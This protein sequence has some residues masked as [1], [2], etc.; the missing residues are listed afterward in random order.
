M[1]CPYNSYAS[2]LT[3]KY[4]YRIFRVGVDAGF[5]C[6]NRCKNKDGLGCVYCDSQGAKAAYLR[7]SESGYC[8]LSNFESQIDLMVQNNDNSENYS[9]SIDKQDIEKQVVKGLEFVKRRYKAQHFAVYLQSFSNTFAPYD[10]LKE[11]YDFVLSLYSWD[12]LIV[13]TRP[14]CIDDKKLE[15][16]ASYKEK[17][18]DVCIELGLQS[19]DD[20]I[21]KKMN[22]GHD[23]KCFVNAANKVKQ[24]GLELCV[25]VLTGFPGEGPEQLDKTIK[26]I[27]DVHPNAIKIHNLNIAAGTALYEEYLEGEVTTPCMTRHIQNVIWF[28]RNIPSDIVI[29]RLMCETPQ[30]RLA[31]PRLFLDKNNFLRQLEKTMIDSGYR[32]GDLWQ[33]R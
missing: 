24:Y 10:K 17:C 19:A 4:G 12:G 29:E 8:H 5:S 2:H 18:T 31:S 30:H 26:T 11:L 21:L 15:L 32:Q 28:L 14:D 16:L 20:D 25:H 22:R 3:K 6:P 33:K 13:S 7:S 23:V 27:A 1:D 9:Y